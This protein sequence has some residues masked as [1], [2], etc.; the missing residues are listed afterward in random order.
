MIPDCASVLNFQSWEMDEF[1]EFDDSWT[2]KAINVR[3]SVRLYCMSRSQMLYIL[4]SMEGK[5]GGGIRFKQLG[6][7][8]TKETLTRTLTTARSQ[9]PHSP[10]CP[11]RPNARTKRHSSPFVDCPQRDYQHSLPPQTR[12]LR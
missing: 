8:T 6:P 12:S 10:Q 1:E 4:I 5:F 3:E 11:H 7:A 2:G 9:R